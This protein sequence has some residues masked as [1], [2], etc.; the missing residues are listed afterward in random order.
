MH[1]DLKWRHR[2]PRN[3]N[4]DCD[5][6]KVVLLTDRQRA[7]VEHVL[8]AI[9][10]TAHAH[11]KAYLGIIHGLL[12]GY[13]SLKQ[14]SG[15]YVPQGLLSSHPPVR[16]RNRFET[17]I[18]TSGGDTSALSHAVCVCSDDVTNASDNA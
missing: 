11:F 18:A 12:A 1:G 16:D 2:A 8:N 14:V 4:S 3:T 6:I 15:F 9:E 10:K 13:S 7:V 17:R 5:R